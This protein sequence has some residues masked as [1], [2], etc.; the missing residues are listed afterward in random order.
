MAV[1]ADDGE[2]RES[3][4][5]GPLAAA[6]RKKMMHL[7]IRSA[8]FAVD[9]EEVKSTSWNLASKSGRVGC[10]R[11]C[12]LEP[13][14]NSLAMP[15]RDK[16]LTLSALEE[17]NFII[18]IGRRTG[19]CGPRRLDVTCQDGINQDARRLSRPFDGRSRPRSKL[20]DGQGTGLR[21]KQPV[22][23]QTDIICSLTAG[24]TR[25]IPVCRREYRACRPPRCHQTTWFEPLT[26]QEKAIA[27]SDIPAISAAPLIFDYLAAL[28]R[29]HFAR[30]SFPRIL[31]RIPRDKECSQGRVLISG[32]R[33][34]VVLQRAVTGL[35]RKER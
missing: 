2:V 27:E 35:L 25:A 34:S 18:D 29:Q 6:E 9:L 20:G 14:K 8:Q 16:A 15:M 1:G 30:E 23:A 11:L 33:G 13:A 10:E 3:C 26:K 4:R 12:D 28:G 31:R 5:G 21:V 32:Q 19:M 24:R 7:R 17:R 22:E